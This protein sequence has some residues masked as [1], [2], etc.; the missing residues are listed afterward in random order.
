MESPKKLFPIL[1]RF[2]LG[3]LGCGVF[4]ICILLGAFVYIWQ[5][6]PR[7]QPT[8]MQTPPGL[9]DLSSV[10]AASTVI[11]STPGVAT[12]APTFVLTITPTQQG[13]LPVTVIPS[14]IPQFDN[15][16]PAGKIVFTCFINQ[17]DQICLMNADGSERK[18]LTD[19]EGTSFYASFSPDGQTIYFS[20]RNTGTYEIYSMNLR[21]RGL[22]RL[23]RNIGSLYAPELSPDADQVIFTNNTEGMQRIWL[24]R[25][26]GNNPHALSTGPEDIDPTWSPDSSLIAFASA[27]TGQRQLYVMDKDGSNVRQITNLNDMGGRST[28]SPNGTQLAFYAGPAGDHNIYVINLDGTGLVQL[29]NGGD[30]LGP[31]WAPDG[32]WITFTSFR[33]GNNE[34]YIMHPDGT[35]VTRLTNNPVSDW[36]PRWGR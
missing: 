36:Q 20:S 17:I 33:D 16:P 1:D 25:A 5:N 32:D 22:K 23:T 31:S 24:M 26:D 11:T 14:P 7:P 10:T 27:R 12:P 29:T 6:P 18:Q 13:T 35:G 2:L 19:F 30:N 21:G 34:I 8:A 9:V 3:G 4:G 28:W 15:S